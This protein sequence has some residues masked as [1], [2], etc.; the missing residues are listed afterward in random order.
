LVSAIARR[1]D[2]G[3]CELPAESWAA[4]S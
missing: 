4:L 2:A 3:A 1:V